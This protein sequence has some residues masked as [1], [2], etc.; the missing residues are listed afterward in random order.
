[1]KSKKGRIVFIAIMAIVFITLITVICIRMNKPKYSYKQINEAFFVS[2]VAKG[3]DRYVDV[4]SNCSKKSLNQTVQYINLYNDELNEKGRPSN[5]ALSLDEVL[6][7]Y[8]R[9][10]DENGKPVIN[11]LPE[12][13]EDYLD[14][15]WFHGLSKKGPK[16]EDE[17]FYDVGYITTAMYELGFY[18][19][20]KNTQQISDVIIGDP[21]DFYVKIYVYNTYNPSELIT[22]EEV[23]SAMV[24]GPEEPLK[25][26]GYWHTHLGS[27]DLKRFNN[28]MESTYFETYRKDYPD[29]PIVG[30]MDVDEIKQ[31]IE[32]MEALEE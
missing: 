7:F 30:E 29:A 12:K 19:E 11:N 15:F 21:V 8:D 25:R 1:M 22:E 2:Y 4:R 6:D 32:Y 14:W 31:L 17:K 24:G 13:I 18:S 3:E 16:I 28:K 27:V 20:R 23:K 9:E 5:D 10:F 26:Y